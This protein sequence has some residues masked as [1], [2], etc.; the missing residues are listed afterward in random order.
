MPPKRKA[1]DCEEDADEAGPSTSSKKATIAT[2]LL[3]N[4]QRVRTLKD[5]VVG[6]GPIIYW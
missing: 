6:A 3:V 1:E 5:G 4:P 2:D